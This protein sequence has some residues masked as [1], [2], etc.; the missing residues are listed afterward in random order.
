MNS[1]LRAAIAATFSLVAMIASAASLHDIP[2]KDIEGNATTLAPWRGQVMLIVNV[3]SK[4]G[5]TP[6]YAALE[7]LYA[8]HKDDGFVVLGFPCNQFGGQ[9]PGSNK[10]IKE[11]CSA[12][13]G[14]TFPLFDKV[15]VNGKNRHPL[16]VALAGEASP[17]PGE[18]QWNFAKF[19]IGRDG[20]IVKRFAPGTKPDTAEVTSAIAAALAAK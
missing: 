4:C 19:L 9:E 17:F 13:Y 3:A 8:K 11:F 12:E 6:Q 15:D 16:Y 18:I 10:Q 2:V 1:T 5:N 7:T 20:T 14:V